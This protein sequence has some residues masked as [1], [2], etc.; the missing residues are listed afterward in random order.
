MVPFSRGALVL[1][2]TATTAVFTPTSAPPPGLLVDAESAQ[3]VQR[4]NP[5]QPLPGFLEDPNERHICG[6]TDAP[7][8]FVHFRGQRPP[9]YDAWMLVCT[10]CVVLL[11]FISLPNL[12][13]LVAA[14]PAADCD[15]QEAASSRD[16]DSAA[17]LG[18]RI[19]IAVL[20]CASAPLVLS[21]IKLVEVVDPQHWRVLFALT[22]F[23]EGFVFWCF[24]HMILAFLGDTEEAIAAKLDEAGPTKMWAVPP[25]TCFIRPCVSPR[26]NGL[27]DV[28]IVKVLVNQF[29]LFS[30]F[31]AC[32]EMLRTLPPGAALWVPR[33]QTVSIACAFLGI[34]AILEATHYVLPH[35]RPHSKFWTIKGLFIASNVSFR[36]STVRFVEDVKIQGKCYS[37]ETL[38][39]GRSSMFTCAIAVGLAVLAWYAFP[40]ED[41]T[42]SNSALAGKHD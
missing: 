8:M 24:L 37:A 38:A 42:M 9:A 6:R 29:V 40:P 25:L 13:Q 5:I 23:Y 22:A 11:T 19:K 34:F 16:E 31:L 21:Y 33:V 27:R 26:L 41:I 3:A 4:S 12:A 18:R 2:C 35:R 7:N 14:S 39:M 36:V 1:C 10:G 32:M 20:V 30:P 15:T 28:K 17:N